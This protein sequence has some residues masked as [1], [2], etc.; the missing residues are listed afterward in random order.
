MIRFKRGEERG[1]T[2]VLAHTPWGWRRVGFI[3]KKR[4]F[5]HYEADGEGRSFPVLRLIKEVGIPGYMR[6][7]KL[8][9]LKARVREA[10]TPEHPAIQE[11]LE[12]VRASMLVQ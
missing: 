4:G 3:H 5:W 9:D 8:N 6:S 2:Y 11:A 1:T 10:L 12:E 7:P